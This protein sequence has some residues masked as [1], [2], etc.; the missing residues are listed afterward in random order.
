MLESPELSTLIDDCELLD[1]VTAIVDEELE[2]SVDESADESADEELEDEELEDVSVEEVDVS[3]DVDVPVDVPLPLV[4]VEVVVV[5]VEVPVPVD[6]SVPVPVPVVPVPVVPVVP[7]VPD[8]PTE[9]VCTAVMAVAWF[10]IKYTRTCPVPE[11]SGSSAIPIKGTW[12]ISVGNILRAYPAFGERV[13]LSPTLTAVLVAS[14][15]T[16][17]K[18][19][20]VTTSI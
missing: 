6:V 17:A 15:L 13:S 4:S 3:V 11:A 14:T 18:V 7:V 2:E 8:V 10:N 19:P 20:L 9:A 16:S 1:G 5:S 12:P